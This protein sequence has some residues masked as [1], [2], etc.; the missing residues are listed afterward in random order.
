[1]INYINRFRRAS[2]SKRRSSRDSGSVEDLPLDKKL[3]FSPNTGH[4]WTFDEEKRKV[5]FDE[6]DVG[7]LIAESKQDLGF[8]HACSQWLYEYQQFV[9]GKGGKSCANFNAAVNSLQDRIQGCFVTI[10]DDL[11][12][13]VHF[14]CYGED[15]WINN[16]NVNSV[17]KLY[18]LRPTEKARTYLFGLRDKLGLILSRCHSSTRY[19]GIYEKANGLFDEIT[20]ALECITPDGC[21]RLLTDGRLS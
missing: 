8:L 16:I 12:G 13:G 10:Y 21:H 4:N 1:M 6:V 15:F 20:V 3:T 5:L 14:E 19:D 17:L 2:S 9:W 7:E 18:K 11:T